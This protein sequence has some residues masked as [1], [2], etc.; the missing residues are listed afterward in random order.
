MA[1]A[2]PSHVNVALRLAEMAQRDPQRVAVAE[3]LGRRRRRLRLYKQVTFRELEEDTNRIAAG[4]LSRGVRPGMRLVLLVPAGVDFVALVFALLKTGA[5]MVL[6]DP[7]MG[8]KH[9]LRCLEECQPAGFIAIPRVHLVRNVLRRRFRQARFNVTVGS[10]W[11]LGGGPTLDAVRRSGSPTSLEVH[12]RADDPAAIIFTSGSTGAP[13]GVLYQHGNFDQQVIEIRDKYQIQPGEIDLPGFP[14][15]ALFNA[16]MGVTTVFPEMDFT[17]PSKADPAKIVAAANDWQVTQAFGSPALLN[18]VGRYCEQHG[19]TL[20][21]L[22]RVL[23]AGAPVPP[24]VLKRM[25]S[26]I[27]DEGEIHTPYGATEA[28]PVASISARDVL[29]DTAE[30]SAQ[31]C[32]TCVGNRFPGIQWRVIRI[33][34]EILEN[35]MDTEELPTGEI[36]ELIVRG[37]VVTAKYVTCLEANAAHKIYE[38]DAFW[39]RMGD[40]GYLD[41]DGRFWFC[42]RKSQRI[43]HAHGTMFT[44]PVESIVNQHPSVYRSALVGLGPKGCQRPVVVVET[45]PEHRP[46]SSQAEQRLLAALT[47]LLKSNALTEPVNDVLLHPSLP[48]DTRH[49]SKIFRE[50]L[51][52]WAAASFRHR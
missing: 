9:L 6:I 36:G 40:V 44:V 14:L 21:T 49:N 19:V 1:P 38:G 11:P 42:G 41:P 39:H 30:R 5:V 50:Q 47:G 34:D 15:F 48:V 18:V 35:L 13:K 31:G 17:K 10:G 51:A 16:A 23:S 45:W 7:G 8:R 46:K 20:P 26:A 43:Q 33:S 32:G 24:H 29:V 25:Q 12:T 52:V 3:P 28:L 22:T 2:S 27:S 4:L 37:P